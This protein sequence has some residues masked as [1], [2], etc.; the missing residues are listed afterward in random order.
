[1]G[2]SS[3]GLISLAFECTRVRAKGEGG[4]RVE[5]RGRARQ[6]GR[7]R[8]GDGGSTRKGSEREIELRMCSKVNLRMRSMRA[9][10][11]AIKVWP[12]SSS[13]SMQILKSST[14]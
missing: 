5:G 8:D 6:R 1:M 4:E 12:T 7:E 3:S 11:L 2:S 13:A 10:S 9:S 14:T